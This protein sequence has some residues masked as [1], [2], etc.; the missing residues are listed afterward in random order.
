MEMYIPLA[1]SMLTQLL[2]KRLDSPSKHTTNTTIDAN[3]VGIRA[4][5]GLKRAEG[6]KLIIR[7]ILQPLA[8]SKA[9]VHEKHK[10][11]SE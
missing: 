7:L 2:G 5:V 4:I 11:K 10:S 3:N 8:T 6:W 9:I 1:N